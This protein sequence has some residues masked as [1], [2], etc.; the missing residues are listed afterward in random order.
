VSASYLLEKRRKSFV[1]KHNK[2]KKNKKAVCHLQTA[3]VKL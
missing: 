3:F 2:N 1:E